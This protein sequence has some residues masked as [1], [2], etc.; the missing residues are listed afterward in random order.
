MYCV[1]SLDVSITL[2][3]FPPD[4]L[5]SLEITGGDLVNELDELSLSCSALSSQ[6]AAI[7]WLKRS[8]GSVAIILNS[9]R[10]SII[11]QYRENN[12]ISVLTIARTVPSDTGQYICDA[13][14]AL[15][16]AVVEKSVAVPG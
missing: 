16:R 4:S 1:K 9:T 8:E 6:A 5:L 10:T 12:T 7:S 2:R 13:R 11:N 14:N 3:I 15:G